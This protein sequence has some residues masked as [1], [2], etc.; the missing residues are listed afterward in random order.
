MVATDEDSG[1]NGEVTYSIVSVRK[2]ELRT[3]INIAATDGGIPQSQTTQTNV[4]I[5]FQSR[6]DLQ[7]YYIDPTSGR[8]TGDLLCSVNIVAP[9]TAVVRGNEIQLRCSVLKNS[10]VEALF[11]FN[12]N[13]LS[14]SRTLRE[15][16]DTTAYTVHNSTVNNAGRYNCKAV[17]TIGS[18][19]TINGVT[20]TVIGKHHKP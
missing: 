16:V 8:L 9:T 11:I 19:Q 3:I 1:T 15:N 6:C 7:E 20:V 2:E 18:L 10:D 5:T 13:F 14:T 12:D 17:S 4:T